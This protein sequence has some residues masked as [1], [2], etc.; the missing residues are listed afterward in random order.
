MK[1]RT[2]PG[3]DL[4]VSEVCLGTM[5]WGEQNSEADAHAQ[6]D[7]AV[8]QGVNFIDTAEMYPVPPNADDAGAY[9]EVSSAAGS[10]AQPRRRRHRDQGGGTGSAR[11]DSQRPHRSHARRHRRGRRH[12]PRAA[13]I[14]SI[15]LLPDPLA[16]AQRADVRR[17]RVRTGE[18]AR[19]A[20]DRRAGRGLAALIK[21]GK[22][23]HYGLSNETAWGVC[24][25]RRV[26]KRA[27]RA[28]PGDDPEQLQPG[29]AR[30]RQ[31][32]RGNAVS[33]EACRCSRTA[34]SAAACFRASISAA[35]TGGSRFAL[36]D[37]SVI[38]LPQADRARGGRSVRA[39]SRS[40]G[41]CRSVQLALG[42]VKSR[43]YLGAM[44]IGA[45]S[46]AQLE[47]NIAA[48]RWSSTFDACGDRRTAD[49]ISQS[50]GLNP[51]QTDV[52]DA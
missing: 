48:A 19:R 30:R 20:V 40:G 34:R 29:L 32:S 33:R 51:R 24:E 1:H 25:F 3:T 6:L 49:P 38:A 43:W 2:L 11:M 27:G 35:R 22:I 14:D 13:Q 12:E 10:R 5:T 44:I 46:L 45:T 26:A 36:F 4:N 28:G 42:Y 7:Y 47:E 37:S 50:R 23:R 15:D 52:L 16:A 17:D 21:A 8:A 18:G 9:R 39:R 41:A 31:R